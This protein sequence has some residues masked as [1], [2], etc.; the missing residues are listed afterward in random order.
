ME[1][2]LDSKATRYDAIAFL[3]DEVERVKSKL[4]K[5]FD[6][7]ARFLAISRPIVSVV[8]TNCGDWT[9]EVKREGPGK[10]PISHVSL[11]LIHMLAKALG[12][13]YRQVERE[14]KIHPTWLKAL[15]LKKAPSHAR[16]STF[17]TEMGESFFKAFFDNLTELLRKFNL[18]QSGGAIID[19]VPILASVNFAKANATPKINVERVR[20]FFSSVDV[21]L[22]VRAL[23]ISRKTKYN[24]ASFIRF[25]TFEKLGGF[26]S[27][28]QALQ[29]VQLH[30]EVAE[31]L[32]FKNG[33]V[34]SQ[35]SFNYFKNKHGSVPDLLTPLVDDVTDFFERCKATPEDIDIDFF[36]WSF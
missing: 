6:P 15:K 16:L 7:I 18:I 28:A 10:K 26:M 4:P 29:F 3:R 36:F 11:T 19:S 2:E 13:E 5:S 27:T 20:E 21:D 33:Q 22:A 23:D 34:P 30:Q 14:L 17:R 8:L 25:F 31:I 35:P 12:V 32:G 24:P 9:D 1:I